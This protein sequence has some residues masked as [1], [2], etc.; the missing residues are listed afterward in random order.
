MFILFIFY[1]YSFSTN[2]KPLPHIPPL[3]ASIKEALDDRI[4][5]ALAIAAFFTI[6]TGMYNDGPA[7]GWV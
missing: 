1:E 4:L 5:A 6:I 7:W 2:S 3:S